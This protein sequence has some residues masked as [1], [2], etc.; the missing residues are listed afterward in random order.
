MISSGRFVVRTPAF[1]AALL[2]GLA[3]RLVALPL[4]GAEEA[5]ALRASSIATSAAD[6]APQ[7]GARERHT[8]PLAAPPV[9]LY[10]LGAIGR[11]HDALASSRSSAGW[12][13]LATKLPGLLAA[14]CL[15][16]LLY[17]VV[18]QRTGHES[19]ARWAALA[20]WLNP[21]LILSGDAL[22]YLDPL[23]QL[24]AVASLLL[25][26]AG[27]PAAAGA[28]A[29]V[30]GLTGPEGLLVAPALL[31]ALGAV[32]GSS[33]VWR[34]LGGF[35]AASALLLAP[36]WHAGALPALWAGW[37]PPAWL[38]QGESPDAPTIWWLGAW[39][40]AILPIV[41]SRGVAGA[42]QLPARQPSMLERLRSLHVPQPRLLAATAAALLSLRACW[43]ARHTLSLA[44][45]A[46]VAAFTVQAVYVIAGGARAHHQV[47]A[48]PLLALAAGLRPQLRGYYYAL[49]AISVLTLNVFH[50]IGLGAAW[51]LPRAVTWVD[52]TV[53]LALANVIVLLW[54]AGQVEDDAAAD[55]LAHYSTYEIRK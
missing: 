34:G 46:A 28:L 38:G 8:G 10:V 37:G 55:R 3:V 25:V 44:L 54:F 45:Q 51:R 33:G 21:A 32:R 31:I 35:A 52:A 48:L 11:A 2:I 26:H 19:L 23:V 36:F 43:Q 17:R 47:L 40:V 5:A 29:A 22:G 49:T 1:A 39:I 20:C 27:A 13:D 4:P 14:A 53:W 9:A 42:L 15:T 16:F 50:G 30:A 12:L 41:G 18:R 7:S 6:A 24:T